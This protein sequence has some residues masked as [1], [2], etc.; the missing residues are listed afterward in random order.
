MALTSIAGSNCWTRSEDRIAEHLSTLVSLRNFLGV[1][2]SEEAKAGNMFSYSMGL[3]ADKD[4]FTKEEIASKWPACVI[5]T[6]G[7]EEES[8]TWTF[9]ASGPAFARAGIAEVQL[10]RLVDDTIG[11]GDEERVWQNTVGDIIDELV[12]TRQLSD[13]QNISLTS[14]RSMPEEFSAV[15]EVHMAVINIQWGVAVDSG[16]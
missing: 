2:T 13:I 12:S 11:L 16:T 6:P 8:I 9:R 10:W 14:G 7:D 15:G 1:E 4:T 5:G 3:P